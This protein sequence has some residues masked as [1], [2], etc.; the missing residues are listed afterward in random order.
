MPAGRGGARRGRRWPQALVGVE[1]WRGAGGARRA[2]GRTPPALGGAAGG[3]CRPGLP[4]RHRRSGRGRPRAGRRRP[5]HQ[6]RGERSAP[7]AG[8]EA[9]RAPAARP[10]FGGR[11]RQ[12]LLTSERPPRDCRRAGRRQLPHL[13]A[14]AT[15]GPSAAAAPAPPPPPRSPPRRPAGAPPAPPAPRG[16]TGTGPA[17]P[18]RA[19][20]A[21]QPAGLRLLPARWSSLSFPVLFRLQRGN[22]QAEVLSVLLLSE[23]GGLTPEPRRSRAWLRGPGSVPPNSPEGP[24]AALGTPGKRRFVLCL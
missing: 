17:A 21:Q 14:R 7:L 9:R 15:R 24:S 16:G 10:N 18:D 13:R 6:A 2:G 12:R 1:V 19:G 3:S 22:A 20:A 5:R 8:A 11:R 23:P 4:A